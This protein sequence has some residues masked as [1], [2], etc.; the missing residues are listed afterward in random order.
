MVQRSTK[1]RFF[2]AAAPV[3]NKVLHEEWGE[4]ASVDPSISLFENA[5]LETFVPILIRFTKGAEGQTEGS[6]GQL[7]GSEG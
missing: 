5:G 2:W 6:K 3:G 4:N 1:Y 7:E